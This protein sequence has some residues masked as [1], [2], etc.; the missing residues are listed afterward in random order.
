MTDR[1]PV[2]IGLCDM[3]LAVLAVVVV[4]VNPPKQAEA[5]VKEKAELLVTIEWDVNTDGDADNHL[6]MPSGK[7]VFYGARQVGCGRLDNDNKGF[8]DAHVTLADGSVVTLESDKET[9]QVRCIEPGR[10]DAGVNLYA[11]R[12]N[13]I[14]QVDRRDLGLKVH[15]EIVGLNPSVHL[16]FSKDVTLDRVGQT[17]N[18]ASFEMT[19]DGSIATVDP[20]LEPIIDKYQRLSTSGSTPGSEP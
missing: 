7:P 3:A 17:I 9:I 13:N 19:R 8:A 6:M 1:S 5:G 15:C 10:Y 11:Y 12:V 18:W 2:W 16:I 20:P 14:N 4:A